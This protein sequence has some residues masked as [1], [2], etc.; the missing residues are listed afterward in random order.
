[1]IDCGLKSLIRHLKSFLL[2][3]ESRPIVASISYLNP[4]EKLKGKKIIITGGGRGLGFAMA[5]RFA[6]EGGEV[7]ISGRDEETLKASAKEIGCKYLKL[8]VQNVNSFFEFIDK[9]EELLGGI[10]CL[11]NNAGISL[12]ENG[13]LDVSQDQFDSQIATNLRGPFFM[14]Q[15]FIE[16]CNACKTEGFKKILFTSSETG[17]T[18][19]ERPYGLTKVAINSLV[20]GLA[21]RY[22][23]KGFRIHAIAPG[24]TISDMVGKKDDGNL[25]G[26]GGITGRYYLPEEVAEV[27]AFLLCDASNCLNGQ[28]LVCNEG[29]TINARWR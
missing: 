23:N 21:Y 12:H 10:N 22:V 25:A 9:A 16:K 29:K 17:T 24:V 14:A 13:I 11:V 5:K 15:A 1:M 4:S 20:Q 8:D 6:A 27:A 19:D 2:Q 7:L 26:G 18:V 3:R 28:V